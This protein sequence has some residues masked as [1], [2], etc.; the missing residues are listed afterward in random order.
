[1]F[2]WSGTEI[3]AAGIAV[4]MVSLFAR[5]APALHYNLLIAVTGWLGSILV[6]VGVGKIVFLEGRDY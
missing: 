4:L 3:T 5:H 6:I 2:N 1:M